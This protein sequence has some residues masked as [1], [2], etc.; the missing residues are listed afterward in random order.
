MGFSIEELQKHNSELLKLLTKHLPDLLWVKDLE[1]KY[2]YTNQAICD[3]LLMA[4]DTQEPIGKDDVFFALRERE[5]HKDK[6]DW[7]TFGEL[8]FNSDQVVIDNNKPM[9]F[10]E[11]GNVKGKLLYL[12]VYKAPFCDKDGNPLGTVGTG[13]DITELKITQLSLEKSL[14]TTQEQKDQ[15]QYQATHDVL[16]NLPNRILLIEKLKESIHIAQ[17]NIKQAVV[18]TLDLDHFKEINDSLGHIF[19]DIVLVEF[20]NRLKNKIQIDDTLARLGGDEFS[21]ILNHFN[22]TEEITDYIT[23]IMTMLKEPFLIENST[24][25]LGVSVGISIFPNDGTDYDTLLRNSDAA[26]N[27]AKSNG[28]HTYCFYNEQMTQQ[29]YD[30]VFL[31]S[32]LRDALENDEFIVHYQPQ[33]DATDNK[34]VGME[35]LVRWKHPLLG[36]ITPD[37]FIPLA[38]L[39]GMIVYI[40]RI[41]MKKALEQFQR[42]YNEGFNPGKISINLAIKQIEEEDFIDFLTTLLLQYKDIANK[43][44]FEVTE[45]QI[46]KNPEQSIQTLKKINTLGISISI[47]DFGTGYSSLAYLKRLPIYKLKIDQSFVKDLPHDLEDVAICK[48]I[49]NLCKSLNLKVIAEGVETIEQKDFLLSEGCKFIQGFFYSQAINAEDMTSYLLQ[50]QKEK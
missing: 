43:V 45:S 15:L 17:K 5:A 4:K 22:S 3:N 47:D 34:I 32:A 31:E 29:A 6:A 38:E 2:L 35:T 27:K 50:Y 41:V 16:T 28:R 21:I 46:M 10:E 8:C 19:G 14:K 49:I 26:M 37:N 11:Y 7:H 36:I 23:E 48:T 30:R 18:L 20:A 40:D 9:R 39:T 44:E 1:G 13:R 33:I 12:E 25:Y 42:W 24:L